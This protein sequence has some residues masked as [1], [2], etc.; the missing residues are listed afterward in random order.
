MKRDILILFFS[1]IFSGFFTKAW[2]QCPPTLT[3]TAH[4]DNVEITGNAATGYD[5]KLCPGDSIQ[6][7]ASSAG[8]AYRWY[9]NSTAT[10]SI[11][12]HYWAPENGTYKVFV[13]DAGC[14]SSSAEVR[15]VIKAQ[16]S[17]TISSNRPPDPPTICADES[18][19]LTVNASAN[20]NWLWWAPSAIMGT[21]VS[22]FTPSQ[23]TSTTIFQVAGNDL[24][25]GCFSM[26]SF[27]VTV[28]NIIVGG[29]IQSDQE[30]CSGTA[31]API[32]SITPAS[33]G[34]GTYTYFWVQ[35]TIDE[36]GHTVSSTI[37]NS[38]S[39]GYSHGISTQTTE[40]S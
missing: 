26:T 1:I 8:V 7:V 10:D 12:A 3:L 29:E 4:G 17:F 35:R 40:F 15:V 39:E 24:T 20:S 33:G 21:K 13:T 25:S 31:P 38:N 16:P 2:S 23:L 9:K 14:G 19:T 28:N 34:S 27:K 11:Q 18:I 22:P 5:V 32:T 30:I 37:I 36:A 6:I